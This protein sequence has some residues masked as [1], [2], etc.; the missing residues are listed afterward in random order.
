MNLCRINHEPRRSKTLFS[1]GGNTHQH[2][3]F[4]SHF[5]LRYVPK[6]KDDHIFY[7]T[8]LASSFPLSRSM[9]KSEPVYLCIGGAR[10]AGEFAR[11]LPT[12]QLVSCGEESIVLLI[13][14]SVSFHFIAP[15]NVAS[16]NIIIIHSK[17]CTRSP[18]P[19]TVSRAIL[20]RTIPSLSS[21]TG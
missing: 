4:F 14:K 5:P 6:N 3:F 11:A 2:K 19:A 12:G 7:A 17:W 1:H 10:G 15:S 8:S 21:T 18:S 13:M 20:N 9:S 16:H